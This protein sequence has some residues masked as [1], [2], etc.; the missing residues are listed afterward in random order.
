MLQ[1]TMNVSGV[2]GHEYSQLLALL[3]FLVLKLQMHE[4][5]MSSTAAGQGSFCWLST[6]FSWDCTTTITGCKCCG[7]V[8]DRCDNQ[9]HQGADTPPQ[10]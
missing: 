10:H 3:C 4:H 1:P 6:Q 9:Q 2:F 8:C 5:G 7:L